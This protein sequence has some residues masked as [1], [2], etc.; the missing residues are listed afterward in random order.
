M[1]MISIHIEL[2]WVL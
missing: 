1:P 2:L